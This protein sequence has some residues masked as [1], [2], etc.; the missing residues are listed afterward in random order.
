MS[1]P[2]LPAMNHLYP[3]DV[4]AVTNDEGETWGTVSSVGLSASASEDGFVDVGYSV[5]VKQF[6]ETGLYG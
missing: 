4:L 2:F 6:M 1:F 3:G 5:T